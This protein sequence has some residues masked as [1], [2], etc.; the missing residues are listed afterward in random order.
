VIVNYKPGMRMNVSVAEHECE[1]FRR[2]VNA[3]EAYARVRAKRI[4]RVALDR[5]GMTWGVGDT[6]MLSHLARLYC[7]KAEL[8]PFTV[9]LA[10]GILKDKVVQQQ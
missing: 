3:M 4:A 5:Y 6:K 10:Q 7:V 8:I 1:L 9:S 2:D